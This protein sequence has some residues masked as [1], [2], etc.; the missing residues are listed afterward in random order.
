MQDILA[1]IEKAHE[2]R[3]R[4]KVEVPEWGAT[5]WFDKS[6]TVARQQRIRAGIDPRNEGALMVSYILHEAQDEAG[7]PVFDVN[8]TSRAAL[9]GKADLRVLYRIMQEVG[10]PETEAEAKNA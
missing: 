2:A 4:I 10:A 7:K 6:I 9:E 3:D 5:L 1:A 8:A